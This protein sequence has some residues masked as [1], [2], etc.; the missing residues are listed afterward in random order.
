MQQY[1][2]MRMPRF[3]SA[4]LKCRLSAVVLLAAAGSLAAPPP[5]DAARSAT[6]KATYIITIAG[7]TIGRAEAE[8]R[9]TGSR[10]TAA[11]SGSTY[12]ISRL[13]SDAQAVLAGNGHIRGD[14]VMPASYNLETT[15]KG[16]DTSVRMVM[17]AG[18]ITDLEAVPGLI[19]AP[20]RVP[21]TS[22]HKR[23]IVD[24]VGAFIVP[25]DKPGLPAGNVACNRTVRVFDGWQRFDVKLFY[26]ETKKINGSANAYT[27]EV[28]A[29]G[30]RYVPVAGHR[31][32]RDSVQYM[33]KNKRLEIWLAPI[34]DMPLLVPYRILIG[35]TAGDLV[36]NATTFV[37]RPEEKRAEADAN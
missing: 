23:N 37:T 15:E 21:L 8:S 13:V 36:I 16:F 12:G 29:C 33:A 30:A 26:K 1:P 4:P 5:A 11:I 24:P 22:S 28:I 18:S 17:R 20:D 14:N 10:Y 2:G 31:P 3:A 7:L 32:G 27:G 19:K 6:F 35:T 25:V 34:K 9:F